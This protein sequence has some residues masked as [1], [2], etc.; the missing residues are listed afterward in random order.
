MSLSFRVVSRLS[1]LKDN[2]NTVLSKLVPSRFHKQ[3]CNPNWV[4]ETYKPSI[5]ERLAQLV[6]A[7]F[8]RNESTYLPEEDV[9]VEEEV[10]D[11][12]YE[13]PSENFDGT[14]W[15]ALQQLPESEWA[16]LPFRPYE[17]ELIIRKQLDDW[18]HDGLPNPWRL[19]AGVDSEDFRTCSSIPSPSCALARDMDAQRE[20]PGLLEHVKKITLT[21]RAQQ[22]GMRLA[23]DMAKLEFERCNQEERSQRLRTFEDQLTAWEAKDQA[24][25]QQIVQEE[26]EV[27]WQAQLRRLE[28]GKLD[29]FWG[30]VYGTI[31]LIS[32]AHLADAIAKEAVAEQVVEAKVDEAVETVV[33]NM[34]SNDFE[35]VV[36]DHDT[37]VAH[38]K[39][40]SGESAVN[41]PVQAD[42]ATV[43]HE[44][45]DVDNSVPAAAPIQSENNRAN[46]T[47]KPPRLSYLGIYLRDGHVNLKKPL[48]E[49]Q[50]KP[51]SPLPIQE[52]VACPSEASLRFS[53]TSFDPMSEDAIRRLS[54]H[55]W[56]SF[57]GGNCQC[58]SNS[59]E[60][61]AS[62]E[63]PPGF[64]MCEADRFINSS[65]VRSILTHKMEERTKALA[66]GCS[67]H[68][69]LCRTLREASVDYRGRKDSGICC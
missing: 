43:S 37:A 63:T 39:V 45:F 36:A 52:T 65:M 48:S 6:R 59:V 68:E 26:L 41:P 50:N 10:E 35:E 32:P 9:E 2:R 14:D 62:P 12:I 54:T 58:C 30:N 56:T 21:W 38:S 25:Q 66:C 18:L 23:A 28:A 42:S 33:G 19:T 67:S 3:D 29:L 49:Q 61:A 4:Y 69:E 17:E 13:E 7:K 11:V 20:A 60:E 64:L 57:G 15:W 51:M 1:G 31:D 16:E 27:L 40:S 53:V 24:T 44:A 8:R 47:R 46:T 34:A 55:T 5:K 22:A